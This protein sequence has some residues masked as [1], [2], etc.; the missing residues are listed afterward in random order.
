MFSRNDMDNAQEIPWFSV[1]IYVVYDIFN[2]IP[3][4]IAVKMQE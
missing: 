4:Y 1:S 2:K 3:Y